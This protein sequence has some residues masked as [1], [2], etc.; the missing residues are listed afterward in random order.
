MG[1]S[2]ASV[3]NQFL[4][5]Q[6]HKAQAEAT[7]TRKTINTILTYLKAGRL[8]K[9][10]S[11][12]FA[13]PS[14]FPYSLYA[15][16]FQ[17]CSS[18]R[19]IVE[20]RKVESHLVTFSPTPPI[21]LLNRAIET[22]GKCGFL[23]DAGELFE[24]MPQRDGGS[25]NAM[26]T[27]YAQGGFPDEALSLF[28]CMNK[29]GVYANRITFASV[30]GS[31]AAASEL[32]LSRQI[33][34]L[35]TKNGF[36]D[37]VI[38]GS[39]L[40][41]VYG[42]CQVMSDAR[43]MF[44]EIRYPNAIT[45]NVIV[46][47]YFD[48]GDCREAVLMFSRMLST[49]IRPLKF[50]LSNA[51]VACSSIA[52]LKEGM[53]IHGVVTKLG[54]ED[55]D[56]VSSSLINMYVRCG[57]MDDGSRIFYQLDSKDLVTWTSIVSAYAMSGK[58]REGRKLF[59]EMPE[60]NVI[61]W[62]AMLA[63]Y[64]YSSEWLEALDFVHLMLDETNTVD[65]VTLS[66][67]LNL[68]AG[69]SDHEMGKQIHGYIY[70]Y[71]FHSYLM[72]GNSLLDMYGKCGNLSSAR[73]WFS[74]MSNW[75]DK[76][77]WNALLSSY[78]H[79]QLSEQVLTIFSE[80]QL[81]TKPTNYTF[82]TLL[83]ACANTLSLCHGKQIHEY[84]IRHEIEIDT[85]IRTALIYMYSRCRCL[86]YA[87]EVL[88]EEASRD[89]ILWNTIILGC[90]HNRR[91]EEALELFGIMIEEGIKPDH[92]TFQGVLLA[93]VEEGLVEFGAQCFKSMSNEY[94]VLP[95][96]EHYDC[97]VELYSRHGYMDQLEHFM[98][99]MPIEP[100]ISMLT[101][102]LDACKKHGY[103]RLGEWIVEQIDE[104]KY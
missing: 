23:N 43:K 12:L 56:V 54:F 38:L 59:D 94:C 91:G 87:F 82:A 67:M 41:D 6:N 72:L 51:L 57:E 96:P 29:S 79:H 55:D 81:E 27:A 74:V 35:L 61:S 70:R 9:A 3:L 93:C 14:L 88:K 13:F 60:R 99:T 33:H 21:F 64:T 2:P 45:W 104:F 18:H 36:Y 20:A 92:V 84:L 103:S 4:L 85:V 50:T 37:N 30:L 7:G 48:N 52:A 100:T 98:N 24:E 40:V 8:R 10:V 69:L 75:R 42:K 80:M 71:G 25:W 78:A 46:R 31:C 65:H 73:V 102:A 66:L 83:A 17:I 1:E 77:S 58:T 89:V 11:T 47:R 68:S 22:Y 26:I 62:N 34:G 63:G 16:L 101:V 86:G 95:R 5:N 53:Q 39:S 49:A 28:L 90:C 44:H 15:H 32:H 76:V 97:M 19:A